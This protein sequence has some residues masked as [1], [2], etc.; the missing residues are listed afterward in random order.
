[1]LI[2]VL[3]RHPHGGEY[4]KVG[5]TYDCPEKKARLLITLGKAERF[6]E[7]P[8]PVAKKKATAKKA[9]VKRGP[10]RPRK[11]ESATYS[12]TALKAED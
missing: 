5:S 2:K 11:T 7:Q 3:K 8:K 1:M 6:I 4:R 10:G 12:T 9:P